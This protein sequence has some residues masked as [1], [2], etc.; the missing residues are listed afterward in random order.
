MFQIADF[1][2]RIGVYVGLAVCLLSAVWVL[3][4]SIA[5]KR[6]STATKLWQ[7]LVSLGFIL[8]LL[9]IFYRFFRL[10]ELVQ[11][12]GLG[13]LIGQISA[14]INGQPFPAGVSISVLLGIIGLILS[15]TA[16]IVYTVQRSQL[17]SNYAGLGASA[18]PNTIANINYSSHSELNIFSS[19]SNTSPNSEISARE[20]SQTGFPRG[21]KET[22][23][24]NPPEPKLGWLVV[25]NGPS[26]NKEFP[27]QKAD[28]KIGRSTECRIVLD[29]DTVSR[30]H[31][32]V[33]YRG[34]GMFEILDLGSR[35]GTKV[36]NMLIQKRQMLYDNDVIQVGEI[37]MVFKSIK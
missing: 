34:N 17:P 35:N 37:K 16:A 14:Q 10:P 26:A 28:A 9:G 22:A 18:T 36:N 5:A 30:E 2:F 6:N 29:S 4:D 3:A 32:K 33:A 19:D 23:V 25:R 7:G 21:G 24:L 15:L 8:Q 31:A 12:A 13:S 11:Q 27:L 1:W 20:S